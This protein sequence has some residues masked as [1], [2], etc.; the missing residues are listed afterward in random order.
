MSCNHRCELP[1]NALVYRIL[2]NAKQR[3]K[4]LS[5]DLKK[6]ADVIKKRENHLFLKAAQNAPVD[7][8]IAEFHGI[9]ELIPV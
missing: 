3:Y 2:P 4:F 6:N 9:P 1:R 8:C 5:K 7:F